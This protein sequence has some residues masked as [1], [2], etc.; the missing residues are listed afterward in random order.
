MQS[1]FK[2]PQTGDESIPMIYLLTVLGCVAAGA[3]L[4]KRRA[5]R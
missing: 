1:V 4:I 5:L 2:T 3:Y